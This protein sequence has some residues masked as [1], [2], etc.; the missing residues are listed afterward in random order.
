MESEAAAVLKGSVVAKAHLR[1]GREFTKEERD[2]DDN[3][4]VFR[5]FDGLKNGEKTMQC[6]IWFVGYLSR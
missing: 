1:S 5:R 4:E 3:G 2:S 6:R